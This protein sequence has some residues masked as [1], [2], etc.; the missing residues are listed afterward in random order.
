MTLFIDNY[1]SLYHV[2]HNRPEGMI[3]MV[4]AFRDFQERQTE[5]EP[6]GG[7]RLKNGFSSIV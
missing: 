3:C 1:Y 6:I 2:Q 5:Y 7:N 4:D